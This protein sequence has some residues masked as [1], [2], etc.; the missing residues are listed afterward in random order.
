MPMPQHVIPTDTPQ[1]LHRLYPIFAVGQ[2]IV[3]LAAIFYAMFVSLQAFIVDISTDADAPAIFTQAMHSA[4]LMRMLGVGLLIL[5]IAVCVGYGFLMYRVTS[6]SF[7]TREF[8]YQTGII[9]KKHVSI[10]YEKIQ[11][12]NTSQ[13]LIMRL[14]GLCKVSVDT[15]GGM[16][17]KNVSI[18]CVSLSAAENIR[19][20]ATLRQNELIQTIRAAHGEAPAGQ[21]NEARGEAAETLESTVT[22]T[23]AT[24]PA[25][26]PL[27]A[28]TAPAATVNSTTPIHPAELARLKAEGKPDTV[29]L[30]HTALDDLGAFRGVFGGDEAQEQIT[31]EHKLTTIEYVFATLESLA[32]ALVIAFF[33]AIG[34]VPALSQANL[35]FVGIIGILIAI[36]PLFLNIINNFFL[37]GGFVV[38]RRGNRIEVESGLTSRTMN[39]IALDRVQFVRVQQ[40]FIKRLLGY[41]EISVGRVQSVTQQSGEKS[42][43][44]SLYSTHG[45]VLHPFIKLNE[46]DAFLEGVIPEMAVHPAESAYTHMRP[47]VLRRSITRSLLWVPVALA[48]AVV[49]VLFYQF[50]IAS[51]AE[52]AQMMA[53]SVAVAI[54]QAVVVLA[55]IVFVYSLIASVYEAV[56]YARMSGI[57]ID[58][59]TIYI[60][61]GTMGVEYTWLTKQKIQSL[62]QIQ[63]PLQRHARVATLQIQTA[64]GVGKTNVNLRDLS[65][66]DM[67]RCMQWFTPAQ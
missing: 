48:G 23:T 43:S 52:F 33:G 63:N 26:T 28:T 67:A 5:L 30:G 55:A 27:T 40:S 56:R 38:R 22:Q 51:D 57:V 14:L 54:T 2:I 35:S 42:S 53:E 32:K 18:P 50:L 46:V 11:S 20:E 16:G 21:N 19:F 60:R 10:P 59:K 44:T 36:V 17:N 8:R 25:S 4:S 7:T 9:V 62:S 15:A 41:A 61:R 47:V 13:T 24:A 29:P 37:L 12:I 64:A 45:V 65:N 1:H 31:Y 39:G 34:V 58:T 6:Y 66:E 3:A 49:L